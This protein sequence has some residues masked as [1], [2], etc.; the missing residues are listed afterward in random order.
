M[1]ASRPTRSGT[2]STRRTASSLHRNCLLAHASCNR[3]R[4]PHPSGLLTSRE[5][6]SMCIEKRAF[7]RA[8]SGLHA[9]I[10]MHVS[11]IYPTIKPFPNRET[12]WGPNLE[13]FRHYFSPETTD[14]QGCIVAVCTVT[15]MF[16]A[17]SRVAPKPVLYLL[18]CQASRR[19]GCPHPRTRRHQL[20]RR[21]QRRDHPKSDHQAAQ[22]L[23]SSTSLV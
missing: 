9:S 17:R 3:C 14:N 21:G 7:Y 4:T 23:R 16:A 11:S 18:T 8:V 5:L 15:F 6:R 13:R 22:Q 2:P 1:L 20:R 12:V 19:Q 10:N